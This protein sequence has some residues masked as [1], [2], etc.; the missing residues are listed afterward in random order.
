MASGPLDDACERE[1]VMPS[2]RAPSPYF[3]NAGYV[4]LLRPSKPKRQTW[5]LTY[6][7]NRWG[8]VGVTVVSRCVVG[9]EEASLLKRGVAAA[10]DLATALFAPYGERGGWVAGEEGELG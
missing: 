9:R 2:N 6:I 1:A 3:P 4:I 7:L 8:V 10:H 5:N